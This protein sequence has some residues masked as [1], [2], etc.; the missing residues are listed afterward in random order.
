MR[1]RSLGALGALVV[2]A[3]IAPDSVRFGCPRQLGAKVLHRG[4]GRR[5]ARRLR[6]RHRRHSGHDARTRGRRSTRPRPRSQEYAQ[7]LG[8]QHNES[9]A[10]AGV[11]T[12]DKNN[13]YSVALNGYSAVMTEAQ[14]DAIRLQ[15]GVVRVMEDEL[16][17][18]T[19]DSSGTF[20][21][22][23]QAGGAYASGVNG[24]GVTVGVIDTGIWPEH[25]SFN[26]AGF[27]GAGRQRGFRDPVRVRQHRHRSGPPQRGRRAVHLQ[28]QADR[29]PADAQHVPRP[30][31][32][33]GLRVRLGPRRQRPRDAHRVHRRR[34]CER[35]C[36]DVRD[37]AR[38]HHRHRPARTRDRLQGPRHAGR[39]RVRP[40][41]GDRPGR[42]RR[43]RRDQLLDRRRRQ[44]DRL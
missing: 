27:S 37:P 17:Q 41:G 38:E 13:D 12:A 23:T 3:D 21:G 16:Q 9:L 15:K 39:L 8:R 35:R 22:L 25:P 28:Q 31:R 6:R 30:D 5:A 34:Q 26:G 10:D 24:S 29:C 20:L 4:H 18:P 33:R 14:A 2:L 11:S 42:R 44:R 32:R 36:T 1:L 7:Y 19:T 40:D 43:R